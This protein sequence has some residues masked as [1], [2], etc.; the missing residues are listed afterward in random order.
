MTRKVLAGL[1]VG[2]SAAAL[3]LLIVTVLGRIGDPTVPHAL[4]TLE[5]KTYDWRLAT[6]GQT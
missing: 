1:T 3:V 4:D 6:N 2:I 5:L